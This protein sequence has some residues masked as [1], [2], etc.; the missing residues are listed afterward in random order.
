MSGRSRLPSSGTIAP[1]TLPAE[2][3]HADPPHLPQGLGRRRRRAGLRRP[4]VSALGANEKLNIGLIG[5]G[6]RGRT[7]TTRGVK[8]GAQR[9]RRRRRRRVPLRG[10]Q[11]GRSTR[12]GHERQARTSTTTTASCSTTRASTRSSSPPRT[13]T[14]RTCSSPRWRPDKHAYCEKPLSHTIEEGK[15][16]VDG[17][18]RRPSE[19]VQVG[20]QR[21]SGE[22]WA[23][24]RDVIQS[25]TSASSSG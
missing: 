1:A 4:A 11:A 21:H 18:A 19:I 13:T 25:P 17:G 6:N 15:E 16:M 8:I 10:P 5:C 2:P 7:I 22:H 9:R 3:P 12:L 14:T 20:N 23:R 24:C